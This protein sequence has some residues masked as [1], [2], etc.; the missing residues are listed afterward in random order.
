M[1]ILGNGQNNPVVPREH[2]VLARSGL[3]VHLTATFAFKSRLAIAYSAFSY[4]KTGSDCFTGRD[5]LCENRRC[6]ARQL[7]CDGF[8]Q[9]GD[10]TDEPPADGRPRWYSRT[11]NYLFPKIDPLA[12]LRMATL[13]FIASSLGLIALVT[14]LF[15]LLYRINVRAR[16][17]V[18]H[19]PREQHVQIIADL[20]AEN[21][22]GSR[23]QSPDEPPIYEA[24]PCYDDCIKVK[25]TKPRR[26]TRKRRRVRRS[27]RRPSTPPPK[28]DEPR[29]R[30]RRRCK[31]QSDSD[32]VNQRIAIATM[33]TLLRTVADTAS[34]SELLNM[35][36]S[37]SPTPS[38]PCRCSFVCR[39]TPAPGK[40][41][42]S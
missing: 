15:V 29:V 7:Y 14:T 31:S 21:D 5:F 33:K 10:G 27:R 8:D 16:R 12:D 28:Y 18:D 11:P 26:P 23:S 34:D 24:P 22:S 39:C 35:S 32:T 3:Y 41:Y 4:A 1:E 25:P 36:D 2:V 38:C 6:I 30:G 40:F 42:T 37:Q 9:C 13:V 20:L 17:A 19:V